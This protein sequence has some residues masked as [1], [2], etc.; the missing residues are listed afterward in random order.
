MEFPHLV[1]VFEDSLNLNIILRLGYPCRNDRD[2]IVPGQLS[3][4]MVNLRI[5]KAGVNNGGFAVVRHEN[6]RTSA[7]PFKGIDVSLIPVE[8]CFI[9]K[10]LYKRIRAITKRCDKEM[11]IM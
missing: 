2:T 10:R 5:V 3:V 8:L 4:S 9:W 7:I 6:A 11:G 1:V